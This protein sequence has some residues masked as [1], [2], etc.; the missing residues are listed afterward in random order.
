MKRH[1]LYHLSADDI[2]HLAEQYIHNRRYR[3]L[4]IDRYCEGL[5]LN[6]LVDKHKYEYRYTQELLSECMK[7]IL[8]HI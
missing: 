4:F 6:E 2:T 8:L 7:D 3:A 5:S 1:P